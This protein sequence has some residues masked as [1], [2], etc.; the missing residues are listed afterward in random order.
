MAEDKQDF[1]TDQKVPSPWSRFPIE[2]HAIEVYTRNI[3]YRFRKEFEKN[4]DYVA[5]LIYPNVYRFESSSGFCWWLW[6]KVV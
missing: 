4:A 1:R 2:K 5:C 3:Y 6:D